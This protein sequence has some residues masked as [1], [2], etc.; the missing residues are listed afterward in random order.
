MF[1][2][3]IPGDVTVAQLFTTNIPEGATPPTFS[4]EEAT[5]LTSL[6]DVSTYYTQFQ[7]KSDIE[8]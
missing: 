1:G 8:K 3:G 5:I 4:S 2:R 7:L 6:A